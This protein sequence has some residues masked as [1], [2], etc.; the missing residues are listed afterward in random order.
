MRGFQ[1]QDSGTNTEDPA[2]T[3]MPAVIPISNV[4]QSVFPIW[5]AVTHT[6]D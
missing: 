1:R 2:C 6:R 4:C 5:N 3:S